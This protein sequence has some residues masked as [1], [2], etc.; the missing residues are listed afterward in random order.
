MNDRLTEIRIEENRLDNKLYEIEEEQR[1][2]ERV[3]EEA[4]AHYKSALDFFNS[5]KEKNGGNGF[6]DSHSFV[7]KHQYNMLD[8]IEEKKESLRK[9]HLAVQD[10]LDSLFYEKKRLLTDVEV[11]E[12]EI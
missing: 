10:D 4:E 6:E 3:F 12:A 7:L 1:A 8:K 5:M 11:K 9:Q 2:T